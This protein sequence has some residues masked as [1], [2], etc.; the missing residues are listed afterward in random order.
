M[1][2][3]LT[4]FFFGYL[5]VFLAVIFSAWLIFAWQS[6]QAVSKSGR[7]LSCSCCG[8]AIESNHAVFTVRCSRCGIRTKIINLK[9]ASNYGHV[10]RP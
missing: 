4:T 3:E 1:T 10:D 6:H 2:I 9:E 8:A 7:K 5:L